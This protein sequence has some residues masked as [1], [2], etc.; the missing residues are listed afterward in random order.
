MREWV[1]AQDA[2]FANCQG[3]PLVLPDPAPPSADPLARA[4]RAYQTAAAYFYATRYD[5][6][7][8][9]F[10]AIAAD[11]TSPWRPYG[12]YLAA[13]ALIRSGT[14]PEKLDRRSR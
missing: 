13:R 1:R 10:Q 3:D 8:K 6:A 9:R 4:D 2:V 5:E 12:R 14:I 7:A 11:T